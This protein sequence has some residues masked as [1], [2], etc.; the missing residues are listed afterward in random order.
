MKKYTLTTATLLTALSST[1]MAADVGGGFDLSG[2]LGMVSEYYWRGQDQNSGDPAVQGGFDLGHE[3][4]LYFGIWSSAA[5][6][7]AS[8]E[9]DYYGGY[10]GEMGAVAYDV[11]MITYQYPG[12]DSAA[13]GSPSFEEA[14]LSL[15]TTLG[16]VDIGVTHYAAASDD[17]DATEFS[18]GTTFAGI[19]ASYT[20]GD[21]DKTG[22]Y[23]SFTL[24]KE[25]LEAYP[26]ELA[27]SYTEMDFDDASATDDDA[28]IF[29]ISKGF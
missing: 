20:M 2:N 27:L 21:Y 1:A 3:S 18:I 9:V 13:N 5:S 28:I 11:G 14:Y 12:V 24:S 17:N 7:T 19:G 8:S 26:I 10:A 25:V 16:M 15:G 6:G 23:Y 22:D 4:G 29:G